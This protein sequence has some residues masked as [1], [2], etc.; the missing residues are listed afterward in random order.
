[1]EGA[2]TQDKETIMTKYGFTLFAGLLAVL[3]LGLVPALSQDGEEESLM[4]R[5]TK[6]A[7]PGPE[8]E[9]LA[10][11]V[12]EWTV[13]Q[14]IFMPGADEPSFEVPGVATRKMKWGRYLYEELTMGQ[15]EEEANAVSYTGF[16][17]GA[18]EF[19]S[20]TLG[21]MGTGID[22]LSGTRSDDGKTVTLTSERVEKGLD[23]MKIRTRFVITR[24]SS[25][26]QLV[27]YFNAFG[28]APESKAGELIYK[29]KK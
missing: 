24:K 21:I 20:T 27:E 10:E 4:E 15:G 14:R 17:N 11:G 12:G 28:D 6:L 26:E 5:W 29:R 18:R 7:Q 22:V 23:N 25:D 19:K 1:M 13:T 2:S 8:H 16:D 3:L 9:W